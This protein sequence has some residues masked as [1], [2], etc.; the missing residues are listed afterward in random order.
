MKLFKRLALVTTWAACA[1]AATAAPITGQGTWE[2]TL[3]AR[4]SNGNAVALSSP[5]ATF[6]YDTTLNVTWQANMNLNGGMSWAMANTWAATLTAG[7]FR[8]WRLPTVV[9]SGAPGCDLSFDGGT[10]CGYNI[11]TQVGNVYSEF[12][13]LFYVTLGN[14]ALCAPGGGT[15]STCEGPQS[16]WGLTNTAYFQNVVRSDYWSGTAYVSTG[17]G[18][19]WYFGMDNLA[20]YQGYWPA[21]NGRFVAVVRSGDVLGGGSM[22]EAQS[23]VLVLTALACMALSVRRRRLA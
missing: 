20:G 14:L 21:D 17:S 2:S 5:L 19:A 23:L 4:D 9:D 7:G 11:Q 8:D 10:D 15:P 12:A 22:P 16:G 13:H 1:A 6:F 18:S 3:R